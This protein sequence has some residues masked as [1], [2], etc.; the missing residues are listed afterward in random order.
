METLTEIFKEIGNMTK[1]DR[2]CNDKGGL[3]HTYTDVYDKL[4]EPFKKQCHIMEIGL[5]LGDSIDLWDKYFENSVI[6]GVDLSI[7]FKLKQWRN[8]V[9]LL[10]GDATKPETFS[11]IDGMG[12]DII[13]DDGSHMEADQMATFNI[14]K[15]KMMY[16]GLYIIEDILSI[17]L[18]RRRFEALHEN[19]EVIDMRSNGRFDNVLIVYRF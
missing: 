17:D 9:R 6:V 11:M 2:G 5:A 16:G 3:I 19:C 4:F 18:A 10:T 13:I 1:E 8:K 7:I 14:L 12:F 15:H